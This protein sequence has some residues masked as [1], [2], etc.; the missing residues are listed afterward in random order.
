MLKLQNSWSHGFVVVPPVS[1]LI[2]HKAVQLLRSKP[3]S[4]EEL[5]K[6]TGAN[7]GY[8]MASI[9]VLVSLG[10][11]GQEADGKYLLTD[12]KIDERV[13]ESLIRTPLLHKRMR[14][15]QISLMR[16]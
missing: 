8:L 6:E 4:F 11:V 7:S 1:V 9:R 10:W 16:C 3:L 2:N 13:L 12:R 14:R 5:Q 15:T